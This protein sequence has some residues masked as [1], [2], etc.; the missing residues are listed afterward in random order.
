MLQS[1]IKNMHI[2]MENQVL[3]MVVTTAWVGEVAN[4]IEASYALCELGSNHLSC[5]VMETQVMKCVSKGSVDASL[6][7]SLSIL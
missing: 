6:R 5:P 2:M 7:V 3:P 1:L 4:N